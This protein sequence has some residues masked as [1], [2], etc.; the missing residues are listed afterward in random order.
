MPTNDVQVKDLKF[1]TGRCDFVSVYKEMVEL[2]QFG[3]T[4]KKESLNHGNR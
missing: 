2:S 3:E 4:M 1:L